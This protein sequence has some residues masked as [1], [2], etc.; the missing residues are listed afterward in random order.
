MPALVVR[1][2]A[3]CHLAA[4]FGRGAGQVGGVGPQGELDADD[5][6][7]EEDGE[8]DHEVREPLF[9]STLCA[10]RVRRSALRDSSGHGV[11]M[12]LAV[13]GELGDDDADDDDGGGHDEGG[14]D[15]PRG[16]LAAF[17]G[18]DEVGPGAT[19]RRAGS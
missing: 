5:D 7:E 4:L 17:V 8:A 12:L 10:S 16:D 11:W 13:V 18:R 3:R 1:A 6:Q 19:D 2:V 15:H 14:D 9:S